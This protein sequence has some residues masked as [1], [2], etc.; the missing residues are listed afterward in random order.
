MMDAVKFLEEAGRMCRQVGNCTNC[1]L[2]DDL[3]NDDIECKI[4]LKR[5]LDH[6]EIEE[7]V[8]IVEKWSNKHPKKT[9]LSE[10]L[11]MFPNCQMDDGVPDG[12]VKVWDISKQCENNF[13]CKECAE[14]FWY[15][16]I[17]EESEA[18]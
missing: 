11:K 2:V 13:S 15:E 10:F 8:K 5:T 18:K 17:A 1:Q 16:E 3:V 9:R 4:N 14:A 7:C 6:E 12:C